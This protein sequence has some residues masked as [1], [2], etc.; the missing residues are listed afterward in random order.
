MPVSTKK[1]KEGYYDY[2]AFLYPEGRIDEN[3]AFF[4]HED[5][6]EIVYKGFDNEDQKEF[7]EFIKHSLDKGEI[8][9]KRLK[10]FE[11]G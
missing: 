7:D 6:T 3:M 11:E 9:F 4:N 5:I 2:G 8:P 10:T 1:N